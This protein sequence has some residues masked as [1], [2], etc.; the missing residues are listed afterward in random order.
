[1]DINFYSKVETNE[2]LRQ[3]IVD[4][5]SIWWTYASLFVAIVWFFLVL[6]GYIISQKTKELEKIKKDVTELEKLLN[7]RAIER[8]SEQIYQAIIW[9][10]L[11]DII[12]HP[13]NLSNIADE[14]FAVVVKWERNRF[15][16]LNIYNSSE[17]Y[18]AE[19]ICLII[20]FRNYPL[21]TLKDV[22]IAKKVIEKQ[23]D[24]FY[25]R[26]GKPSFYETEVEDVLK[27]VDTW[28][29]EIDDNIYKEMSNILLE[30]LKP[31]AGRP[32][33]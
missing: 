4:I 15:K 33:T 22:E 3:H 8:Y 5:L 10:K 17:D 20:L 27:K 24:I 25:A 6:L 18:W 19:T 16:L 9:K 28:R 14:L 23:N 21:E 2:L 29:S 30:L 13:K 11:D 31:N 32:I 1:M 7:W 12:L 26:W